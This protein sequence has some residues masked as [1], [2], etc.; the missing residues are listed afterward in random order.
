MLKTVIAA[1]M[2]ML[3]LALLSGAQAVA[4]ENPARNAPQQATNADMASDLKTL[5]QTNDLFLM[6]AKQTVAEGGNADA[7][8]LLTRAEASKVNGYGHYRAGELKPA[9]DDYTESTH[10]AIQA[11]FLVK[12]QQGLV[13][14]D[15]AINTDELIKAGN[16]RE[17]KEALIKKGMVEAEAFINAAE[18]LLKDGD[19][20][21]AASMLANA[22]T[23]Y[24]QS[25]KELSDGEYDKALE[26]VNLAYKAATGTVRAIKEARAE[27]ITFP[28]PASS[29]EKD[30]LALEIKKNDAYRYFVTQVAPENDGTANRDL[31]K[32]DALRTEAAY[33]MNGGDVKAAIEK[34]RASTDLYIET[35]KKLVK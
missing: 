26:D 33:V 35:I 12:N 29:N 11:I 7:S 5:I 24:L 22:R 14:R 19:D 17:R 28:R 23:L 15:S 32:G 3:T 25:K 10:L 18:R 4:K 30:I 1:A 16:D 34:L 13:M 9:I 31:I 8:N 6:T 21:D 27:I 2:F 20:V